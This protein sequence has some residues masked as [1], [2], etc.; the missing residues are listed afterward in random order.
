M[1]WKKIDIKTPLGIVKAQAPTIISASRSTDIP[2]C[3]SDWFFERLKQGYVKWKNPFNGVPLYVSF[4]N[5]RLIVF[6]TKNPKPILKH[7]DYL[8]ENNINYYFQYTLN[9]YENEGL[10]KNVP[11][12]ES[13]IETFVKLSQKIGK[14]KIIWRFDPYIL[15][16]TTGVN[17]LLKKTEFIGDKL[18]GHTNKFVFSFADIHS[19]KKVENNLNKE[20]VN[21]IEFDDNSMNQ[22][23]IG[24]TELNKKWNF[25]IGTCAEK[26]DL[27]RYNISHNKCI[28]DDLII[29]LFSKDLEL[30]NFMGVKIQES[31]I[32]EPFCKISKNKLL[33]DKG[34]RELCGCMFSKDIGQYNTC[35][36]ECT[37]CYANTSKEMANKNYRNHKNN[38]FS[39][40]ITG[41]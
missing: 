3:Y 29:K 34:Q 24:L 17:E 25:E 37:Y 23:A 31:T 35:P 15:T 36:H 22:L 30:M 32:F 26:I 9:D 6:W 18:K 13:R 8:D 1:N 4:K 19:Y 2:A 33:K 28:D 20:Y 16:D 5:T 27:S 39:E 40:T 21:Y 41:E 14:D 11:N 10:E 7:L 12:I 38:P